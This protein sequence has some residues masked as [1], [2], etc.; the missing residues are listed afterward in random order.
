MERDAIE[1]A[2]RSAFAGVRLGGGVSLR[3][4]DAIDASVFG[5]ET[6]DFESLPE[7]DVTDDWTR[8]APDALP[9][10]NISHLDANGLRYYLPAF[11]LWL[12]DHYDAD[13]LG[14][15][16]AAMTVIGTIMALAPPPEF[17]EAFRYRYSTFTD[18]QMRAVASYVEA[19]PRL[20]HLDESDATS[21]NWAVDRLWRP[22]LQPD[23]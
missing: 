14:E 9:N 4:A 6:P 21:V 17:D 11:M 22:F 12:L 2:I 8:I 1:T 7:S 15:E 16:T 23:T 5:I 18:D 19:L 3:Q 13:R 10:A 20:V